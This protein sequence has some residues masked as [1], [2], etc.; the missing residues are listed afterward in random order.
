MFIGH[1]AVGYGSKRFAPR[2]PLWALMAAPLLADILWTVFLLTGW[3]HA[4]IAVG[5]TRFTPLDLYDYPWSHSLVMLMV[6][7]AV[8]GGAYFLWKREWAGVAAIWIGVVSHWV[9][10][11]ITHRADMPLYPGGPKFGL[12]LW[13]SIAATMVVET[14][15]LVAG[16]WVYA[17]ATRARDW[18]G[19]YLFWGYVVALMVFYV[20]DRFG[21][22]PESMREIAWTGVIATVVMLGWAGWFDAH[23]EAR[24]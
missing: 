8:L 14:V 3:E 1:F 15:M 19:R 10:D 2:A 22:P 11:W 9:L 7:G 21:G 4:R 23:R 20:A 12:G 13:N 16:V 18:I 24:G 5:D 6:W 17:T